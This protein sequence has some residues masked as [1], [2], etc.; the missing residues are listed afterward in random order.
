MHVGKTN[1]SFYVNTSR[2]NH[3]QLPIR[4]NKTLHEEVANL[5]YKVYLITKLEK[6]HE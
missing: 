5:V 4:A 1:E 2:T 6:D 3:W